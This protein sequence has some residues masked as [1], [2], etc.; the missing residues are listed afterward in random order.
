MGQELLSV[1]LSYQKTPRTYYLG[2]TSTGL[3]FVR[4]SCD[5]RYSHAVLTTTSNHFYTNQPTTWGTCH[6]RLDLAKREYNRCNNYKKK[7]PDRAGETSWE[8]VELQKITAK[9][10]RAIKKEAKAKY[11]VWANEERTRRLEESMSEGKNP[12]QETGQ[13]NDND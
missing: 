4:G 9:E 8:I 10:V 11:Q 13:S 3:K 5:D 2:V 6:A 1:N 7:F 12:Q